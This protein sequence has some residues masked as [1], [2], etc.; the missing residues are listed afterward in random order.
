MVLNP[1]LPHALTRLWSESR[2]IF[3]VFYYVYRRIN[4]FDINFKCF[5]PLDSLRCVSVSSIIIY[6][7]TQP[8]HDETLKFC[9]MSRVLFHSD[10]IIVV[11]NDSLKLCL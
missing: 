3:V 4:D 7:L 5:Y 11:T 2:N 8:E 9:V 1:L 6:E 10:D